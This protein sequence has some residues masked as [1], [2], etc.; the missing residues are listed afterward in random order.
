MEGTLAEVSKLERFAEGYFHWICGK[1]DPDEKYTILMRYLFEMEFVW[2]NEYDENRAEDGC[3]L[4]LRYEQESGEECQDDWMEWPCSILEMMYALAIRFEDSVM[5]DISYGEDRT[6][7][8][9]WMMVET[10]GLGMCNDVEWRADPGDA[11]DYFTERIEMF[12]NRL[13]S[14][15]GDGSLFPMGKKCPKDWAETEIWTQMMCYY[16]ERM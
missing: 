2:I 14:P 11:L 12:I 3:N 15:D 4:R 16:N 7:Q 9:F 13:Y 10:L 1:L 5:Y 8:W 6:S